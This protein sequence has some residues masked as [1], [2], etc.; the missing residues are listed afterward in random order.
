MLAARVAE[1]GQSLA[2]LA[3][4]MRRLPQVLINVPNVDKSRVESDEDLQQAVKAEEEELAGSGRVLLRKSGTEP[5]VRVMVEA[6]EHD[7][8]QAVAERLVEVVKARLSL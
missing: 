3:T 1:T 5:V 7:Q 8:A 2:E 6:A 4:V